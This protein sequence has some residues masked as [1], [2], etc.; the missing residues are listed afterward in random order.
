MTAG[1][2]TVMTVYISRYGLGQTKYNQSTAALHLIVT[3]SQKRVFAWRLNRRQ[4]HQVAKHECLDNI[5]ICYGS[6]LLCN[7][8]FFFGT[9]DFLINHTNLFFCLL[10]YLNNNP[11]TLAVS[12]KMCQGYFFIEFLLYDISRVPDLLMH[13][14]I[15]N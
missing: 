6:H 15:K 2:R 11:L 8:I 10:V 4:S 13:S 12:G 9:K 14:L 5:F 7:W 1:A 3:V